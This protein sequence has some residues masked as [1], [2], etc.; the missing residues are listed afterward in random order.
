[1][2]NV[3]VIRIG[4]INICATVFHKV[5][6]FSVID[7][8]LRQDDEFISKLFIMTVIVFVSFLLLA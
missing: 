3:N 5:K 2:D 1:M 8:Q 6:F 7:E 4:T